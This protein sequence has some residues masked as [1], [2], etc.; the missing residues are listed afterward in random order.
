MSGYES[1]AE[2]YILRKFTIASRDINNALQNRE[3]SDA[4]SIAY[5]FWYTQLCDVFI[6][7][8]KSLISNGT[9]DEV[10]SAKA[11]LYTT[12]DGALRMIHPFMPFITE[13]MW[14]RLPRRPGQKTPTIMLAAY[15]LYEPAFDDAAA[16]EAYDLVLSVSKGIRSVMSS[17]AIKENGSLYVQLA[18]PASQKTATD[19]LPSIR[20]LSGKGV[21]S[22]SILGAADS[23]PAGC[24]PF[25]VS[26]SVTVFLLVK[27]IVDMDQEIAKAKK[28]MEKAAEVVRKQRKIVL[29]EGWQ[30]K[31]SEDMKETEKNKLA[32]AETEVR[33]MEGAVAMFEGLKLE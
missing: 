25:V 15:P 18:D 9:P 1:L 14:Q 5:Q 22:V 7:N 16:E 6:E 33:E 13:E 2:K 17:Y 4:A 32:D 11:T 20:S 24:V 26:S 27:G 28:K 10:K 19:E 29:D 21:S 30:K 12:I 8:S 31:V 23:K 3:F